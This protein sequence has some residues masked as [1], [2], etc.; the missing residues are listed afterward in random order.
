MLHPFSITS[1][2]LKYLKRAAEGPIPPYD[3]NPI[4]ALSK[5]GLLRFRADSVDYEIT[6]LGRVVVDCFKKVDAAMADTD[7]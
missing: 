7:R 2:M 6:E 1:G 4:Q 5:R 3:V